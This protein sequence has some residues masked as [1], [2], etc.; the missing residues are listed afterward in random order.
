ME[1][2]IPASSPAFFCTLRV[3]LKGAAG[4]PLIALDEGLS[5]LTR[6]RRFASPLCDE[7]APTP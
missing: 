1:E 6:G 3:I 7:T 4:D 5:P 2:H